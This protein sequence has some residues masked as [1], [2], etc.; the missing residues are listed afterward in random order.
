MM[1]YISQSHYPDTEAI[2]P[3]SILIMLSVWLGSDKYWFSSHWFYSMSIEKIPWSTKPGEGCSSQ[4]VNLYGPSVVFGSSSIWGY[5]RTSAF[6]WHCTLMVTL[7]CCLTGTPGHWYHK[8]ISHPVILSW[9]WGNQSFPYHDYVEHQARKCEISILKSLIWL[10]PSL[11]L[12]ALDF[13]HVK[14]T[15][16]SLAFSRCSHN[17]TYLERE[18]NPHLWHSGPVC[19]HFTT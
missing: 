4:C 11:N 2:I 16:Y 13:Q 7:Q 19:Y 6:F 18:S 8:L 15:L 9:H 14:Q 10:N 17:L 3:W 5:I 1:W 12:Q